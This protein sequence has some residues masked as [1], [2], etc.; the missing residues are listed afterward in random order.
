M[1]RGAPVKPAGTRHTGTVW[2]KLGLTQKYLFHYGTN[3]SSLSSFY[4]V[5]EREK[6]S[7]N[8]C[9]LTNEKCL[10]FNLRTFLEEK[11]IFGFLDR[12]LK[13]RDFQEKYKNSNSP[14]RSIHNRTGTV[15]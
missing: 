11:N 2:Y 13:K 3:F 10:H 6:N 5:F 1:R 7:K 8:V 14:F 9:I 4:S 15:P 12:L